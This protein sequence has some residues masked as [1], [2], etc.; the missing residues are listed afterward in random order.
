V[1]LYHEGSRELQDR[2]DTRRIADRLAD[3]NVGSEFSDAH[4]ELIGSAPMFWLATADADGFPDVSYKGGM[5]GFVR[6]VGPSE[7]AFPNY[8]GNGMYKSLGNVLVNPRVALLFIRFAD[9]PRRLR[10]QGRAHLHH[11]DPLLA[12]WEGAQLVVRLTAERIF[13]NCPRY[14]HH[15]ELRA[16]SDYAPRAGHEP[17]V[18]DWKRRPEFRDHLP[19]R[20]REALAAEPTENDPA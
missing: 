6:V 4:R 1:S 14:L 12:E 9:G 2:F 3:V 18:P 15:L 5:P 20:D 16:Y 19:A 17:P 10:V 11:D 7:L 13:A 8:D